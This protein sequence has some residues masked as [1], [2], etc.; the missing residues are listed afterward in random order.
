MEAA[1]CRAGGLIDHVYGPF[2][3]IYCIGYYSPTE[4]SELGFVWEE[5]IGVQGRDSGGKEFGLERRPK[6]YIS[7]PYR[8]QM[9]RVHSNAFKSCK[10]NPVPF[11][12]GPIFPYQLLLKN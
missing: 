5:G 2:L 3:G 9:N 1:K 10:A 12:T 11:R 4:N 7:R 6:Y 8:S